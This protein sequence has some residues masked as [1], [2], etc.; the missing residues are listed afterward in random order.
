MAQEN[1]DEQC[2]EMSPVRVVISGAAGQIGYSLIPL[3]ASGQ[4]FGDNQPLILH[5]LEIEQVL[6][7]L[8]GVAM[9]IEDGAYP[10]VN[11]FILTSKTEEAFKDVDYA[12]LVGGF[13]RKQGMERKD[14]M[15]KNAPIFKSMGEGLEKYAKE[16]CKV[17]VVANPA[18]T[19]CLVCSSH[20]PK[21]PK[22]NFSA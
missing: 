3:F 2:F 16:T 13:P 7:S 10:L 4:V 8:K 1:K 21:L 17:L 18:N 19:N 14:L 11:G 20:A 12:V 5:L 22:E 6:P 15:D 9:E